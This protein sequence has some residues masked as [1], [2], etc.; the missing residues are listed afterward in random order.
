MFFR[1]QKYS[2]RHDIPF[3]ITGVRKIALMPKLKKASVVISEDQKI[4]NDALVDHSHARLS[5]IACL[6]SFS[7]SVGRALRQALQI[8]NLCF[9]KFLSVLA[10]GTCT[11]GYQYAFDSLI[12][13]PDKQFSPC[14]HRSPPPST[15]ICLACCRLQ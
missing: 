9:H 10:K 4:S 3:Q 13:P 2:K 15:H 12:M 7:T 14:S 11:P 5:T 8:K 1:F 6:K